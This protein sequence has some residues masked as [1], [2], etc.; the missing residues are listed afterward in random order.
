MARRSAPGRLQT[1]PRLP[2]LS[3]GLVLALALALALIPAALIPAAHAL[4][5]AEMFDNPAEEARA[6]AIGRKLRCLVCQNESI[7]DSNAGLARDLRVL[8]RE[9]MAAGDSDAE[10]LAYIHDRYGDYVL[11]KPPLSARTYALWA[12]PVLFLLLGALGA[13][14]YRRRQARAPAAPALSDDD[15]RKAQRIL[16]GKT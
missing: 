1:A 16:K 6:R 3:R 4:D 12:A 8:V 10:V 13:Y 9:R 7:F 5:A 11:L 2:S 15:R 14:G